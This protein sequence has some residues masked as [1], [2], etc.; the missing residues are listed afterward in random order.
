MSSNS[1]TNNFSIAGTGIDQQQIIGLV[2]SIVAVVLQFIFGLILY[3]VKS[4]ANKN[5]EMTKQ[6]LKELETKTI[7]FNNKLDVISNSVSPA[8]T[9]RTNPP[10]GESPRDVINLDALIQ[11]GKIHKIITKDGHEYSTGNS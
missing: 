4:A 11:N 3:F 8:V 10:Y 1:T 5:N 6:Q 2:F 7:D 9:Q